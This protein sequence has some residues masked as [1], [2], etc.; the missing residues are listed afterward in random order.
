[1]IIAIYHN[2]ETKYINKVLTGNTMILTSYISKDQVTG[3]DNSYTL[4]NLS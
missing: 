2:I 4:F 3:N 1:M